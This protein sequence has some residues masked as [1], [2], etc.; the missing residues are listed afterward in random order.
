MERERWLHLEKHLNM[1]GDGWVTQHTVDSA[2]ATNSDWELLC[3][4][5]LP[6]VVKLSLLINY[7]NCI[8]N[9][10]LML[11]YDW[12][13]INTTLLLKSTCYCYQVQ[14]DQDQI[15]WRQG[16]PILPSKLRR[17]QAASSPLGRESSNEISGNV[18]L[19]IHIA[20]PRLHRPGRSSAV[21]HH[22]WAGL[23]PVQA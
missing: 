21:K 16:P 17:N 6:S 10:Y 8:I 18:A 19:A 1:Q 7:K 3:A 15:G 2:H 14:V 22:P 9:M 4:T 20:W 13:S 23:A 11:N 12:K 5:L